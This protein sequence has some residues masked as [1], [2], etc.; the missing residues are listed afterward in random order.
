MTWEPS[1]S[2]HVCLSHERLSLWLNSGTHRR[3]TWC[4]LVTVCVESALSKPNHFFA[5]SMV[6][7]EQKSWF[8]CARLY[9]MQG[10]IFLD[11][12]SLF[13]RA[14]WL[15][16]LR[17]TLRTDHICNDDAQVLHFLHTVRQLRLVLFLHLLELIFHLAV[18]VLAKVQSLLLAWV[19]LLSNLWLWL[20]H[21]YPR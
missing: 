20:K 13:I 4:S 8:T 21:L 15:S 17:L 19:L 2:F 9:A 12:F 7:I 3:L 1:R 11:P 16:H 10:T 6:S 5:L 14:A 18:F